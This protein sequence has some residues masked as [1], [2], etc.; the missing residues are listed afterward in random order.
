MG[1]ILSNK[2]F[3]GSNRIDPYYILGNYTRKSNHILI[4]K[5]FAATFFMLSFVF[6]THLEQLLSV[7][8][9]RMILCISRKYPAYALLLQGPYCYL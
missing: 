5:G 3:E 6:G 8:P 4:F 9:C 1:F 7:L 2:Y